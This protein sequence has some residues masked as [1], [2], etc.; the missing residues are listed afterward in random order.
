[1]RSEVVYFAP[2]GA[3]TFLHQPAIYK[4]SAPTERPVT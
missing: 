3:N 4:H 2:D 1:M